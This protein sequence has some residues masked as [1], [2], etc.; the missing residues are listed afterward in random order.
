MGKIRNARE[1][2]E[3]AAAYMRTLGFT[4]AV[5][6]GKGADDGIDVTSDDAIAQVKWWNRPVGAPALRELYGARGTARHQLLF[7]AHTGYAKPAMEYADEHSIAL[8]IFDNDGRFTARNATAR[9]L[10][11]QRRRP[12]E[13]AVAKRVSVPPIPTTLS[14]TSGKSV[15]TILAED[16][17][18]SARPKLQSRRLPHAEFIPS[19]VTSPAVVTAPATTLDGIPI[20]IR[21]AYSRIVSHMR[22]LQ[23]GGIIDYA[24]GGSDVAIYSSTAIGWLITTRRLEVQDID[25]LRE[26]SEARDRWGVCFTEQPISARVFNGAEHAGI[27][28]FRIFNNGAIDPENRHARTLVDAARHSSPLPS[29]PSQHESNGQS[30]TFPSAG[31]R[32]DETGSA[33]LVDEKPGLY[34][35]KFF[36]RLRQE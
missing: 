20:Q 30:D 12:P 36:H 22:F 27:A 7:F 3:A 28:L 17:A 18:A 16:A 10:V 31:S 8:F 29:A 21:G 13:P 23:I 9:R 19:S 26:L 4:A 5:V 6:T 11:E 15:A 32:S 1:A 25:Q 2:E 33:P 14:I 35:N 34:Q 24:V